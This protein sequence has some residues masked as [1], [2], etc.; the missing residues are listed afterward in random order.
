[1]H[2]FLRPPAASFQVSRRQILAGGAATL[3]MPALLSR[4]AN[5]AQRVVVGTWGG[6]YAHL[7][8]DNIDD[9]LLQ[10]Q[11]IEVVQDIGDEAPR[12]AKVFAQKSLPRGTADVVCMQAASAYLLDQAGLLEHLDESTVPNLKYVLPNL[13]TSFFVPHIYS[14]QILIYSPERAN[15]PPTNF[16]DLLDPRFKGKVGL[17]TQNFFLA[18]MAAGLFESGNQDDFDKSKAFM[19][20]LRDNGLRLYPATDNIGPAFKSGELDAGVMWLARVY[21]WQ[22][23]GIEVK[24]AFPKEGSMLYISGMAVPKNA[25]DKP[26]AFAY[27]NALLE[28]SAQQNFAAKMGYLPTVSNAPLSG[29]V[30]EQL[31]LP[32][33]APKLVVPNY[34]FDSKIQPEMTEWWKKTVEH[35]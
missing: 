8:H 35:G 32:D 1:M 23:A 24:A 2:D 6:D 17:P 20:K 16:G 27:L 14:A 26:A 13:R 19:V 25:P 18:M 4:P 9:P 11:G 30:G 31:K 21:M 28:P 33:P 7:L 10:P 12:I 34:A 22:N 29:K 3:A 5:A 15:P